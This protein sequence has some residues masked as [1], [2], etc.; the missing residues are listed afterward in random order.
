VTVQFIRRGKG[1]Y[2]TRCLLKF[3]RV[4]KK[5]RKS[6]RGKTD[7]QKKEDVKLIEK[8]SSQQ[9]KNKGDNYKWGAKIA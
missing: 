1:H 5:K 3:P 6:L 4:K 2:L 8:P 7:C 9:D